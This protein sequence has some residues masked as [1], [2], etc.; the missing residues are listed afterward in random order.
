LAHDSVLDDPTYRANFLATYNAIPEDFGL[1]YGAIGPV[2]SRP[3]VNVKGDRDNVD[4]TVDMTRIVLGLR[5][6]MPFMNFGS[7]EDWSFDFYAMQSDSEGKSSRVGIRSDRMDHALGWNSALG[8]TPCQNDT[9]T[10]LDA[11]VTQGCVPVNLFAESLYSPII[12]GDFA[13]QAERDYLFDSRDFDTKYRQTIFS[14]FANG[15]VFNLP[16]GEALFGIGAEYREDEITSLPDNIAAEGLMIHFFSDLGAVG[17]KYTK[18][19]FAELELPLLADV[20]A[21]KELTA[22]ISTR[23]TTDE[24]YGD[25]WTYSGKLAWRPVDSLLIRGTV[26]TSYRAPNLRENFL[27]GTTGFNSIFD[28]CIIPDA[29]RGV[30]GVYDPSLDDREPQTLA[31]CFANGVDPTTLDNGASAFRS[32]EINAGGVIDI[33]EEKSDSMSAGITWEQPFFQSFDAIIGVTYYEIDIRNAIIEPS[34]QFIV[35]DCYGDIEGD[36]PFCSRID[37]SGAGFI[38]IITEGF[39]NRDQDKA[40][41]VDIN[42]TLDY[43]T[44]MFGRAVD[45]QADFA[46][47]RT[48]EVKEVFVGDDGVVAVENF[49]GEFYYPEWKGL[50]SFRADVNDWRVTWSTRYLSSVEQD[51]LGIDLPGNIVDGTADTCGGPLLGDVN[52][53]DVGFADNYFVHNM[54]VYYYGDKWTMGA[55][56]RNVFNEAPPYVDTEIFSFKNIPYGAGYD[57]FGRTLFLNVV[58]RLE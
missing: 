1:Y 58:Y 50:M 6:D 49:V 39:I 16:G 25:A 18:E 42:A 55:G 2:I 54:S 36:S 51:S 48:L 44:E 45:L 23:H 28:P 29:A 10:A 34:A 46:F 52:C 19:F 35:N 33:S 40:R 3:V 57:I 56:V 24:Y 31:N 22:N 47:N 17:E 12:G 11:E 8:D 37:R 4:V 26:G 27:L 14:V 13:S 30:G 5:G 41:G 9:G 15:E 20:P 32:T 43:P 21:F 53:R 38:D 7:V